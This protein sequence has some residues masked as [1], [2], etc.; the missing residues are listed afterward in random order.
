M[1]QIGGS[2]DVGGPAAGRAARA[3]CGGGGVLA[4]DGVGQ[5]SLGERW[6]GTRQRGDCCLLGQLDHRVTKSSVYNGCRF[7]RTRGRL[8]C[9]TP[10]SEPYSASPPMYAVAAVPRSPTRP[11]S[12]GARCAGSAWGDS[13]EDRGRIPRYGA[14]STR[15]MGGLTRRYR[16]P[17]DINSALGSPF[18]RC[19]LCVDR[20][21]E[22]S[23]RH[24]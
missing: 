6:V 9:E 16:C 1:K 11:G 20:S 17:S 23:R 10:C 8:P 5:Q 2:I 24:T 4:A 3:V 7:R 14:K 15:R 18:D 13:T 21:E 22:A 12:A 19:G